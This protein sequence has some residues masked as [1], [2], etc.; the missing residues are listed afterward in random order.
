MS[1][2]VAFCLCLFDAHKTSDGLGATLVTVLLSVVYFDIAAENQRMKSVAIQNSQQKTKARQ[3]FVVKYYV[4][5][6][7]STN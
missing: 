5:T 3:A 4:C 7:Y 2:L 6:M 1:F